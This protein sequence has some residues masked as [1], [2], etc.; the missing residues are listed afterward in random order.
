MH[1]ICKTCGAC[2][3]RCGIMINGECLNCKDTREQRRFILHSDLHRTA[4]EMEKTGKILN[5]P[6]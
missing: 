2:G 5:N 6:P 1:N 3:G 4:E